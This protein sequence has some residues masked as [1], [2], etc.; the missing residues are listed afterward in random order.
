MAK[1]MIGRWEK[2]SKKLERWE[3]QDEKGEGRM[4]LKM[5]NERLIGLTSS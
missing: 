3:N 1:K 2:G 4:S 5:S